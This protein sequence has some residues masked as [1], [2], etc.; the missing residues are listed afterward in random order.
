VPSYL[1]LDVC[2]RGDTTTCDQLKRQGL[3]SHEFC[4]YVC[5]HMCVYTCMYV[6]HETRG[7]R[8]ETRD[9]LKRQGL[10][11]HEFCMYVSIHICVYTYVYVRKETRGKRPETWDM[12][13]FQEIRVMSSVCMCVYMYVTYIYVQRETK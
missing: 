12:R 2:E 3:M 7:K 10:M 5:I 13:Q 1:Q 11:S 9:N 6:R 4:M 8:P